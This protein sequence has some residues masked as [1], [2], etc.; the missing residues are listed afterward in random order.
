MRCP[1]CGAANPAPVARCQGCNSD[2]P[3]PVCSACGIAVDWGETLCFR[4]SSL[5][6][7]QSDTGRHERGG[8]W[9]FLGE[10]TR[11]IGRIKELHQLNEVFRNVA[12][13]S[14]VALVTISGLPGIG[15]TRLA[16]TFARQLDERCERFTVAR[17]SARDGQRTHYWLFR[18]LIADRFYL[19]ESADAEVVKRQLMDGVRSIV[20][21]TASTELVHLIGHL[22]GLDFPDSPYLDAQG[23]SPQQ[24]RERACAAMARLLKADALQAPLVLILDDVHLASDACFDLI[25]YLVSNVSEAP[26]LIV[27]LAQP[28]LFERCPEWGEGMPLHQRI[29]LQPLADNEIEE[30]FHSLLKEVPEL[31]RPLCDLAAARAM[32]NPLTL[33]H[34]ARILL[35]KGVIVSSGPLWQVHMERLDPGQIPGSFNELV[36]ARLAGLSD[37][38]RRVLQLA[39]VVGSSFWFGTLLVL[40]QLDA[41]GWPEEQRYWRSD[42]RRDALRQVLRQLARKDLV[43]RVRSSSIPNDSEYQ[44]KHR[45]ERDLLYAQLDDG[46]RT[47]YHKMVAQWLEMGLAR[48]ADPMVEAVALHHELGKNT[49]KAAYFYIHA[50][51]RCRERYA[52]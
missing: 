41:D 30:L 10:Q 21:P 19:G 1:Y 13:S 38:E 43:R 4:C 29:E 26:L 22:G 14:Q 35:E 2:L 27:C 40:Q 31:P 28:A 11:M 51:D 24:L 32:G 20:G 49:K 48:R 3:L 33:E 5:G 15:K 44:F 18:S 47:T 23:S 12:E 17:G 45:L 42:V 34:V 37:E 46:E 39:A 16:S 8:S 52:N 36:Q 6:S 7:D 9:R 50:G 25:Q